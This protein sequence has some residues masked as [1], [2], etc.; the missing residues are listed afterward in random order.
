MKRIIRKGSTDVTIDIFIPDSSSTTGAGLTGLLYNSSGLV[1]YYRRGATGSAT[2]LTLATQTVGGA[3]SDGGFVE[4]SSANM[5]GMYRL[6]LSDAIPATGVGVVTMMLK[7]ATNMA[8]VPIELQL[9]DV[10]LEDA[11]G[12]GLSRLDAA[13]TSRMATFTLPTNF[14]AMSIT[15]G[16][17][18]DI[19]QAAADK[20]WASATRTLTSLGA[21]LVQE[22]WDRATSALTTVGSIGKLLVDNVNATISSRA[23]PAQVNEEVLDVMDVDTHGEPGQAAPPATTTIFTRIRYLYKAWRNKKESTSTENRL[24][25]DAESTVDQKAPQSEA[26]GVLSVGEFISGP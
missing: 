7:G 8:P 18:V 21:S 20:V 6:D 23:T 12:F 1:C 2:A 4:I 26:A 16:G 25:N 24:F 13:I 5:P 3:H 10:D 15:V 17:L 19:T 9:V 14:S 22:I 11:V